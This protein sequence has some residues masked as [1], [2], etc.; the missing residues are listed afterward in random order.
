MNYS[1]T[2]LSD[3]TVLLRPP[4]WDTPTYLGMSMQRTAIGVRNTFN[5]LFPTDKNSF[6]N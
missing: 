5:K 6:A 1:E 2:A 3:L 4:E